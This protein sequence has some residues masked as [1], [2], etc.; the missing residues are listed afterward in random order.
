MWR[1]GG[2]RTP[3]G[4]RCTYGQRVRVR[5]RGNGVRLVCLSTDKIKEVYEYMLEIDKDLLKR[6]FDIEE[7]VEE[8]IYPLSEQD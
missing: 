5:V 7:L 8:E 3:H 1:L 6:M 2:W 4:L